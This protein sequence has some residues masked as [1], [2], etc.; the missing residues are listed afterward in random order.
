M[1]QLK[2]GAI[3]SAFHHLWGRRQEQGACR[4]SV[5]Y[6]VASSLLKIVLNL[7]SGGCAWMCLLP[8]GSSDVCLMGIH[9]VKKQKNAVW[10]HGPLL[11]FRVPLS[12]CR[13]R[14]GLAALGQL[15]A[16]SGVCWV[17]TSSLDIWVCQVILPVPCPITVSNLSGISPWFNRRDGSSSSSLVWGGQRLW[18]LWCLKWLWFIA[19]RYLRLF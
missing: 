7:G 3:S 4:S 17:G 13:R 11:F 1:Y 2:Q 9:M 5:V 19:R 10:P 18:L 14:R 12:C 15:H 8:R 16:D 6:F